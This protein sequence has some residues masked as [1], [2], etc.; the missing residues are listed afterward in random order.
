MS[1]VVRN[2]GAA[3]FLAV[4]S[5]NQSLQVVSLVRL[6]AVFVCWGERCELGRKGVGRGNWPGNTLMC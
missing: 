3:Y 5:L 1:D 6:K 2:V 4:L